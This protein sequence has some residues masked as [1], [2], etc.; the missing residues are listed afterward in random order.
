LS[1]SIGEVEIGEG[2]K[3]KGFHKVGEA[4]THDIRMPYIVVNGSR[5]GPTLCVLGGIHPLEYA[6]IEGVLR[7]ARE[8]KAV[9]LRG[10]LLV[11]PMVNA[12]GFNARTAFNNPIDYVN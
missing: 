11:V 10:T 8:I 7:V 5:P 4:S 9:D 3:V 12:D 1:I 2:E 6:S